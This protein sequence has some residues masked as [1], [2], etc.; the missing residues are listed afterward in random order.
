MRILAYPGM[1][2]F[3][4]RGVIGTCVLSP[5]AFIEGLAQKIIAAQKS[6]AG[7]AG[8]QAEKEGKF[9]IPC[10]ELRGLVSAGVGRRT[11]NPDD[12]HLIPYREKVTAFLKRHKALSITECGDL[13]VVVLGTGA[14]LGDEDVRHD[15]SLYEWAA[16]ELP[17]FVIIAVLYPDSPPTPWRIAANLASGQYNEKTS[18]WVADLL[19]RSFE[20]W[21]DH[22]VVAD[23]PI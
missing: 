18:E 15:R 6:P 20:F 5:A 22:E 13:S 17:E 11:S 7:M 9:V 23:E 3:L 19:I 4:S 12:Y 14:F 10:P 21:R 16:T 8:W 2:A 1:S